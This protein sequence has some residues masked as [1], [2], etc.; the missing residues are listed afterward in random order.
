MA[1]R[2]RVRSLVVRGRK[3]R[4][5]GKRVRDAIWSVDR[6][7]PWSHGDDGRFR[8]ASGRN[9]ALRSWSSRCSRWWRSS[10]RAG[11]YGLL[12]GSVAERT[13][14]IGVRAAMGA[15][16][17][18]ILALVLGQG[19][20]LTL[21]GVLFGIVG[22]TWATRGIGALLFG[23][24]PL[25]LPTWVAVTGVLLLTALMACLVPALRAVRVDPA[26]TLRAS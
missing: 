9:A 15:R 1:V 14:E 8:A 7:Q 16:R 11:L 17:G 5:A 6:N 2:D 10:G 13:R 18:D 3:C 12:A 25:D 23:I 24:S 20:A 19:L 4:G 21:A 22:A 26:S